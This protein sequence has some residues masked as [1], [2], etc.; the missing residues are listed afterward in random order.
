MRIRYNAP[1]TL[2][3]TLLA[4]I[5]LLLSGTIFPGLT[6]SWFSTPAPF[7]LEQLPGLR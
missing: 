6:T 5:V 7:R 4:G 3:F 2:T 1:T